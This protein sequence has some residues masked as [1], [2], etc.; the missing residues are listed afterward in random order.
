MAGR[1]W[2]TAKRRRR[3]VIALWVVAL[4][5]GL[6][7]ASAAQA[8]TVTG[9]T[10]TANTYSAG[11]TAVEYKVGFTATSAIPATSGYVQ[12]TAPAGSTFANSTANYH[13][14]AEGTSPPRTA[15]AN[16]VV[17]PG[18]LGENVVD[19]YVPNAIAAGAT[20]V[21]D[22]YESVNPA[23]AV[24]SGK[25]SMSTSSDTT[26]TTPAAFAITGPTSVS[27]VSVTSTSPT[28]G[29]QEVEDSAT[30]T[31]DQSVIYA[32]NQTFPT[33]CLDG[34]CNQGAIFLT[35]PAGTVFGEFGTYVVDDITTGQV[36]QTPFISDAVDPGLPESQWFK[37]KRQNKTLYDI[38]KVFLY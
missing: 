6:M 23:S 19:V 2:L 28:A 25:F 12:L 36:D 26:A 21:L 20:V 37:I 38:I 33:Q 17:N 29:S 32:D 18:D 5:V 16:V 27:G 14:Q 13:V 11:A 10:A 1:C 22:A 9:F 24:P 7:A 15:A 31:A 35:A 30:F 34:E 8:S 4:A 3:A